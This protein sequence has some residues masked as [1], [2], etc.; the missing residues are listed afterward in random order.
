MWYYD[1]MLRL[2]RLRLHCHPSQDGLLDCHRWAVL[3]LDTMT[4]WAK[5]GTVHSMHDIQHRVY[6]STARYLV[7]VSALSPER[8]ATRADDV[9]CARQSCIRLRH[10][11]LPLD[12][13]RCTSS[14]RL[15]S[16]LKRTSRWMLV[17]RSPFSRTGF[18]K[19]CSESLASR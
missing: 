7:S 16:C 12:Q 13:S 9:A 18:G 4:G 19:C 10:F 15:V 14:S 5:W 8:R 2:S 17:E 6:A 11:Q 1:H 3:Y